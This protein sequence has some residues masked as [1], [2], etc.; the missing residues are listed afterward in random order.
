MCTLGL[1]HNAGLKGVEAA[2]RS[3]RFKFEMKQVNGFELGMIEHAAMQAVWELRGDKA[4]S[5]DDVRK[6]VEK[7]LRPRI[8]CLQVL[9]REQI[10]VFRC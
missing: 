7:N 3:F 6:C 5:M 1:E 9:L 2:L 8:Q 4:G 10:Q